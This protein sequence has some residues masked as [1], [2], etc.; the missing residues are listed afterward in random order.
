MEKQRGISS[1]LGLEGEEMRRGNRSDSF[2]S[3]EQDSRQQQANGLGSSK[4]KGDT[5]SK[6][7]NLCPKEPQTKKQD[8]SNQVDLE[9]GKEVR[10]REHILKK[11]QSCPAKGNEKT[12]T[13]ATMRGPK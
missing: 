1:Q 2:H 6:A 10:E 12:R 9:F 4:K 11:C 13:K 5:D 3:H 7:R 8:N